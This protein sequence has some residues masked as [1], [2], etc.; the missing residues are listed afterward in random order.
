MLENDTPS[1]GN[2]YI[3]QAMGLSK[4]EFDEIVAEMKMLE[5]SKLNILECVQEA[6]KDK[7]PYDVMVGFTLAVLVYANE[8]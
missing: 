6:A 2:F 4:T 1:E 5:D 8:V 7:N 3:E